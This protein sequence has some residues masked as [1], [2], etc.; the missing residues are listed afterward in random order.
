[1]PVRLYLAIEIKG[2]YTYSVTRKY[3]IPY[4]DIGGTR[5]LESGFWKV[6]N[7]R[8]RTIPKTCRAITNPE[9][10]GMERVDCEGGDSA[11]IQIVEKTWN[12]DDY[13]KGIKTTFPMKKVN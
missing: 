13:F 10:P 9:W 2:D 7:N 4:L 3:H 1:M 12:M 5:A 8:F 11:T 6:E